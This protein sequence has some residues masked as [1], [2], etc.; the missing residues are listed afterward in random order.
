MHVFSTRPNEKIVLPDSR[1]TIE[2]V[3]IQSGTVRLGISAPHDA[4]VIRENASEWPPLDPE[5]VGAPSL[6]MLRKLLDKRLEIAREGIDEAQQALRGG[7]EE[8][9]RVLLEK[10]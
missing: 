3:A 4:R 7:R 8:D 6:P 5:A 2:V 9:A 1:T 10:V